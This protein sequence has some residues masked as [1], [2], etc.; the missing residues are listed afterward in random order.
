MEAQSERSDA[1]ATLPEGAVGHA[2]VGLARNAALCPTLPL[3]G[4]SHRACG[5]HDNPTLPVLHSPRKYR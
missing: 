2:V 4:G 5:Y 1:P 3:R